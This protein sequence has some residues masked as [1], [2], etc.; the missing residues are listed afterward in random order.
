MGEGSENYQS[1]L[2]EVSLGIKK[3]GIGFNQSTLRII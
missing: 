2:K 3:L 1:A